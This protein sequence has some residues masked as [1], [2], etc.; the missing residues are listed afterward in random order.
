M[1]YIVF[2]N[3]KQASIFENELKGQLSDGFWSNA[4]PYNHYVNICKTEVSVGKPD[5]KF[6]GKKNYNFINKDLI[7]Y[8][9]KRMWDYAVVADHFE[10]KYPLRS[11]G[12]IADNHE[13]I[14]KIYEN[15]ATKNNFDVYIAH[16]IK[17]F[18]L[19]LK[20]M[21]EVKKVLAS[22]PYNEKEL[23]KEL[24]AIKKTVNPK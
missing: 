11:Y 21:K 6:Y 22:N 1:S 17:R 8:V 24:R 2:E 14:V 5:V 16:N 12:F 15:G 4:R 23:K 13:K 7:S 20:D 18:E 10:D 9:G 3:Y 19:K